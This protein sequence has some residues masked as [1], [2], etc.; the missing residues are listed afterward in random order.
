MLRIPS[1]VGSCI[2]GSVPFLVRRAQP[3]HRLDFPSG[4]RVPLQQSGQSFSFWIREAICCLVVFCSDLFVG[5]LKWR[6]DF[7][8]L[9]IR[10][11]TPHEVDIP[12]NFQKWKFL[13]LSIFSK[14]F[15]FRKK[16][17]FSGKMGFLT[18]FPV[19]PRKSHSKTSKTHLTMT[20]SS[21][22][23]WE[24]S[25]MKVLLFSIFSKFCFRTYDLV[26]QIVSH[27]LNFFY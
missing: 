7:G 14:S 1:F 26:S 13:F 20:F 19:D 22:N 3:D 12:G 6:T 17:P 16:N 8:Y 24:F 25:K 27:F 2:F 4:I 11:W 5:W 15:L 9:G 18:C 10:F 21:W 23:S